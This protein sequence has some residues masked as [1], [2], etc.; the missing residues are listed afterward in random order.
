MRKLILSLG[1]AAVC[2]GLARLVFAPLFLAES[3]DGATGLLLGGGLFTIAIAA[4][5]RQ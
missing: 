5:V 3:A 2:V 4:A 1:F